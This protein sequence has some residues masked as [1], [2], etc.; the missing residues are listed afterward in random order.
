MG[1]S[2]FVKRPISTASTGVRKLA[3]RN[4][5]EAAAKSFGLGA[6][7]VLV[8]ASVPGT[9]AM[10]QAARTMGLAHTLTNDLIVAHGDRTDIFR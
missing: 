10:V 7:H 3:S 1:L 2:A 9:L 4:A 6:S 5:L 8:Q